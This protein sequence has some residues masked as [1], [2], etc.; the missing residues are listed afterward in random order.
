M[1]DENIYTLIGL[2]IEGNRYMDSCEEAI[3]LKK[4]DLADHYL[5]GFRRVGTDM[6][7]C[8]KKGIPVSDDNIS[9]NTLIATGLAKKIE[10][11]RRDLE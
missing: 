9:D 6:K 3:R 5:N 8:R 11:V 7:I 2:A 4:F 1:V 10:Q